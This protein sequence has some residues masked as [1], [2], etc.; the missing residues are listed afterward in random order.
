MAALITKLSLVLCISAGLRAQ[1]QFVEKETTVTHSGLISLFI[2]GF[3][4]KTS[5][6]N[7]QAY[8]EFRASSKPPLVEERS[9][10]INK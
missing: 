5:P 8:R 2:D 10:V 9:Y 3:A 4:S 1:L 6:T 7:F